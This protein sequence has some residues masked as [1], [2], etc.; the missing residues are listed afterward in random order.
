MHVAL[1]LN[2]VSTS[3]SADVLDVLRQCS[4][5][6]DSL[7][8][9]GHTTERIACTLNLDEA[10]RHLL[11]SGVSAVFNLVES[12]GGTDR[13][14]S[15]AAV[16]LESLDVPF[17][18]ASSLA[19]QL[20]TQ[21]VAAKRRLYQLQLPT[22]GWICADLPA[23]QG[24]R[25]SSWRPERAI[26][27]AV[28]EHASLGM[29][30]DSVMTVR[31]RAEEDLVAVMSGYSQRLGT[32]HFAEEFIDG[33]E[34]NLSVLASDEGP[35]VLP[36]AEIEFVNYPDSKPRIVGAAAKWNENAAEYHNTPRRF[37]FPQADQPLLDE[38]KALARRCWEEFGLR[39]YARVD[40]RV[41]ADGQPWILELNA[42]PCLS[43]DAGFAAAVAEAGL[44]FDAVVE[45]I[46]NDAFR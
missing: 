46:L 4:A 35:E 43:P 20:T 36:P 8:N 2:R 34:F 12:L 14:M 23:W 33:R 41:D 16:L 40:F 45:R 13:L 38:L 22:P 29:T 39:G 10:R 42:N 21:K 27:K 24:L 9:L 28:A 19:M 1:L 15:L 32:P 31:D 5:V 37:D 7:R 44:T 18:G 17:T 30:D 3:D 26:I 25:H 11:S 6:E